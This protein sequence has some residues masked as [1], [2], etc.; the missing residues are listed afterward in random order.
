MDLPALRSKYQIALVGVYL[1]FTHCQSSVVQSP[2]SAMIALA[3]P[4]A[5]CATVATERQFTFLFG[6]TNL[7]TADFKD[8]TFKSANSYRIVKTADWLDTGISVGLGYLLSIQSSTLDLMECDQKVTIQKPADIQKERNQALARYLESRSGKNQSELIVTT[9]DGEQH[10]GHL[11]SLDDSNLVLL[12]PEDA[13]AGEVENTVQDVI[14]LKSGTQISGK[15]K[16]Q[17]SENIIIE[18]EKGLQKI[19]KADVLKV[20]FNKTVPLVA[21]KVTKEINIAR[22]QIKRLYFSGQ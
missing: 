12:V 5:N 10:Q 17:N 22:D 7:N 6:L 4:E 16:S 9:N 21:P 2:S 14:S 15:I 3:T 13:P 19:S 8:Y 11:Q 1:L 20:A 18:T